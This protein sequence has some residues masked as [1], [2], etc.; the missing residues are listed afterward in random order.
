M[1]AFLLS[2]DTTGMDPGTLGKYG[3]VFGTPLA[4]AAL[5]KRIGAGQT[6]AN[7]DTGRLVPAKGASSGF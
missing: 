1:R 4:G 2:D 6:F 3:E 5:H 7:D